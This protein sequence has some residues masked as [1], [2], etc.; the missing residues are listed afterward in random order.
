MLGDL[1]SPEDLGQVFGA[2]LTA[3]EICWLMDHEYARRAEDVVWCRSR[4]GQRMSTGEITALD[5]RMQ[6]ATD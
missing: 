3:R 4:L 1:A 6:A 2:N 5:L